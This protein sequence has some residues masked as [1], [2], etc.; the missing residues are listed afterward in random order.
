MIS[1]GVTTAA[2]TN[3][4]TM[5][6]GRIS[7]NLANLTKPMRTKTTTTTGTSKVNPKAKKVVIAKLKYLSISVLISAPKGALYWTINAKTE[8]NTKKYAN[9][10]P[11]KNSA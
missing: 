7:F 6:Y 11:I 4:P 9:D 1:G 10:M 2:T 3:A 5:T 8:G